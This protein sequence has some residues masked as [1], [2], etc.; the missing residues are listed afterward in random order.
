MISNLYEIK[1]TDLLKNELTLCNAWTPLSTNDNYFLARYFGSKERL[2]LPWLQ[3]PCLRSTRIFLSQSL[4]KAEKEP[5]HLGN[6][7]QNNCCIFG[8]NSLDQPFN[9]HLFCFISFEKYNIIIS[10]EC[11]ITSVGDQTSITNDQYICLLFFKELQLEKRR[12]S[13]DVFLFNLQ[14]L[15]RVK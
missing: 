2:T 1:K 11:F 12:G 15:N 14:L 4:I 3:Y 5:L 8:T 9:Q 7:K 13:L 6:T 10:I